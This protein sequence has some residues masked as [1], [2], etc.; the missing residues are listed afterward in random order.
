MMIIRTS[1]IACLLLLGLNFILEQ[2]TILFF[3]FSIL[4]TISIYM[5]GYRNGYYKCAQDFIDSD[6]KETL[7]EIKNK[8]LDKELD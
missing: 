8:I 5:S 6:I 7:D 3:V 2:Y 4:G 1:L